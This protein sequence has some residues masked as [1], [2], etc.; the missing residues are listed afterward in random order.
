MPNQTCPA[1][2][3]KRGRHLD[4]CPNDPG[5]T[6]KGRRADVVV[7]DDAAE[8]VK[9]AEVDGKPAII[10]GRT[11]GP[12]ADDDGPQQDPLLRIDLGEL[13][14]EISRK[15]EEYAAQDGVVK[16]E[17]DRRNELRKDLDTFVAELCRRDSESRERGIPLDL[18]GYE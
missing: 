15:R 16:R 3:A 17:T 9:V 8:K 1:C 4:G 14:H 18:G 12:R 2:G 11:G 6:M 5:F 7:V 10:D 13:I